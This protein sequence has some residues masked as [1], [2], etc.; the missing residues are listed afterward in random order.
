MNIKA[1]LLSAFGVIIAILLILGIYVF[2]QVNAF[3]KVS[4]LKAE[5][6]SQIIEI[7]QIKQINTAITLVAMDSI[8]D[9]GEGRVSPE[10]LQELKEL[11]ASVWKKE[12]HLIELADT[13]E[14]KQLITKIIQAFRGI[15]PIIMNDLVKL[16]ETGASE[17]AFAK[18]DDNIDGAAGDMDGDIEKVLN[19]IQEEL[20]EADTDE[21]EFSQSMKTTIIIGIV[22]ATLLSIVISLWIIRNLG[23]SLT[24]FQ[25]G[26]LGF[27]DYINKK[28]TNVTL[29]DDTQ[30]DEFGEMA[31]TVN[32]NIEKTKQLIEEDQQFI[33]DVVKV[34][35]EVKNGYLFQRLDKSINSENLEELRLTFNQML[36]NLQNNIAGST[37]KILDVLVSFGQLDFTNGIKD[38][39]GKIAVALNEVNQLITNMLVENKS[40]GLTLQNSSQT[41]LKNVDILNT[42]SNSTAASLEETA[43]ALE[44]ITGNIRGNTQNIAQMATNA[45]ELTSS[46]TKGQELATQT[47]TAMDEINEQV[48][49]INDAIGVID[50]IAFQTNILSLNAA[51][52]AATAGEAG[53]GFAVVAQEVRNLASRSAEAAKEIKDLVE[54]AT[55][56]ANQGKTIAD[57]M[58][59]GYESLN[60]NISNTIKLIEGVESASK[61]QLGGIEQINDAINQLDQQTQ[62]NVSVTNIVHEIAEETGEISA[63]IVRNAN[64]KEFFGKDEV[65]AKNFQKNRNTIEQK[66]LSR[67]PKIEKQTT[68]VQATNNSDD[69]WENF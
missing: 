22:I 47:T 45:N 64:E 59:E 3:D 24:T 9:K 49:A 16:I 14:E 40:N 19:S 35:D 15:E 38:D 1:K 7:E 27:F 4:D 42:N 5:R 41:L 30:N 29:L 23:Q 51:V 61:E 37:N 28:S 56:K 57:S 33:K 62:E 50:Q 46:S 55:T 44:E 11:F 6:Y 67:K 21:K 17:D 68:I 13:Q 39:S 36:E 32:N 31:K 52:E 26:L 65:Q 34:A 66:P 43:A 69:E 10:R 12:K 20:K 63:L 58:I 8:I 2:T 54:T 60:N 25:N 48:T 18:L 53:K